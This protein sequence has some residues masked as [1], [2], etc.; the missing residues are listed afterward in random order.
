M[1]RLGEFVQGERERGGGGVIA[2]VAS[3]MNEIRLT[4]CD[5]KLR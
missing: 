4:R 5:E 1:Q 2:D 3:E